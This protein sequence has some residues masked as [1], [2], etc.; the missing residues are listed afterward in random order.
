MADTVTSENIL[1][2]RELTNKICKSPNSD[3]ENVLKNVKLLIEENEEE[4][5]NLT[6]SL[7]KIKCV[8]KMCLKINNILNSIKI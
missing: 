5:S 3:Y 6:T 1:K 2:L 7:T 4:V 8:E